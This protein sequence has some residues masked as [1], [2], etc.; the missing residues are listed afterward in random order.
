MSTCNLIGNGYPIFFIK[1]ICDEVFLNGPKSRVDSNN[2]NKYISLSFVSD[3]NCRQLTSL[4]RRTGLSDDLKLVF[5][6]K[7]MKSIV[8]RPQ[9]VKSCDVS[10]CQFCQSC[11]SK[12]PISCQMKNIV[13]LIT[14]NICNEK[15]VG[16]SK[17]QI[18]TRLREHCSRANS[19]R[20]LIA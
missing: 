12:S 3:S 2:K 11:V 17:R 7:S 15:Y 19:S 13:Y 18:R 8:R 14:C 4:V 6:S 5:T 1:S 10:N 9:T 16:E 20:L